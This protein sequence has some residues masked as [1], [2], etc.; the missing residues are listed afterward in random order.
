MDSSLN[1]AVFT[2]SHDRNSFCSCYETSQQDLL[3]WK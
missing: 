3:T 2:H 1:A